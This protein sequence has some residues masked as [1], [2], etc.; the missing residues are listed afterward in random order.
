MNTSTIFPQTMVAALLGALIVSG[1][2]V[3][4]NLDAGPK[5]D[6]NAVPNADA[7]VPGAEANFG[8]PSSTEEA[9]P[10]EEEGAKGDIEI[11][12]L[13]STDDRPLADDDGAKDLPDG[14]TDRAWH[15]GA[16][17]GGDEDPTAGTGNN[18][19]PPKENEGEKAPEPASCQ[20]AAD[21]PT[22]ANGCIVMACEIGDDGKGICKEAA[23][24]CQCMPGQDASCDDKNPCTADTCSDV[25]ACSHKAAKS[26]DDGNVCTD[27]SC[28]N[29]AIPGQ[30][31]LAKCQHKAA[32]GVACEDGDPC[33]GGSVCQ[34][35]G[36][37]AGFF[38]GC[39]DGKAC[40]FDVCVSGKGCVH[41][42]TGPC[43]AE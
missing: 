11:E 33:T 43:P 29:T 19:P 26:C 13:P 35:S 17:P 22:I 31:N 32:T 23:F 18:P 24:V 5:L 28:K 3:D 15:G 25:G 40:T 8:T 20:V 36:C 21:C 7:Q 1:C 10:G 6:P 41:T 2:A 30:A 4:L 14:W 12:A 27:D 16:K 34:S 37:V 39:D 9:L 42:P 38:Y